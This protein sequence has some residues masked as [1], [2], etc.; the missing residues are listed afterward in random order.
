MFRNIRLMDLSDI[1]GTSALLRVR[2][3]SSA[4]LVDHWAAYGPHGKSP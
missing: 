1:Q 3:R 4:I 2:L